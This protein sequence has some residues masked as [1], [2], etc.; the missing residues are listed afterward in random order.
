MS[1]RLN[2][3]LHRRLHRPGRRPKHFLMLQ[4]Y[5]LPF[6]LVATVIVCLALPTRSILVPDRSLCR[7]F[8]TL[9]ACGYILEAVPVQT[10]C[11][12]TNKSICMKIE[13]VQKIRLVLCQHYS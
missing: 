7:R 9:E 1:V 6:K 3:S 5:F 2:A 8:V 11:V 4:V 13:S 12:T 10:R